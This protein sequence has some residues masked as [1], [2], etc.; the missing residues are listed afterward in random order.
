MKKKINEYVNHYIMKH[1]D[2]EEKIHNFSLFIEDF[3][4]SMDEE[5]S[6]VKEAF[7]E[8]LENFTEEIDEEMARAIVENLKRKDS[9]HS[10]MK[11]SVD[12]VDSVCKQYDVR[13]KVEALGKR[14]DPLK[15]WLS[16]NYVYAVHYS[17]N[18]STVGYIDLA[19]DEMTNKNICF[20]D[21]IKH[22]FKKI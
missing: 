1:L 13:T 14:Y 5:Y 18:R 6:D 3:F 17:I 20:D 21:L 15:F 22:V 9:T 4:C 10:G 12:E 7:Y 16:M 2:H 11:W 19:I 8:E